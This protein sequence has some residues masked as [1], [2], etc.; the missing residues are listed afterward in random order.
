M[1]ISYVI[2]HSL[3]AFFNK[4]FLF[5]TEAIT[6]RR[7]LGEKSTKQKQSIIFFLS[8]VSLC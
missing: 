1:S 2:K 6:E 8:R 3:R 4:A 5:I 7:G